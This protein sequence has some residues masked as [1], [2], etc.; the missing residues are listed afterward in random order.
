ME[1]ELRSEMLGVQ[2]DGRMINLELRIYKPKGSGPFPTIVFN[3]GSTGSG[4]D[5]ETFKYPIRV[6]AL[7]NFFVP[8]GWAIIAPA[9]RGRASS[10]GVYDEGFNINRSEGY[11]IEAKRSVKGAKRALQDI[12]ALMEAISAIAFVDSKTLLIGGES[13]GGILSVAYAGMHPE[14]VSGVI[15]FV[16]GWIGAGVSTSEEINQTVF[17]WGANYGKEMLWLYGKNDSYYPISHS[18]KNFEVFQQKGGKGT[19]HDIGLPKGVD[20]HILSM[21]PRQWSSLLE[22]YLKALH[23]PYKEKKG[24]ELIFEWPSFQCGLQPTNSNSPIKAALLKNTISAKAISTK[25]ELTRF[26]GVWEGWMG[27]NAHIDVRAAVSDI[28]DQGATIIL[29]QGSNN[30]GKYQEKLT[31]KFDNN[32]LRGI[33][34]AGTK[35]Y[36][37]VRPDGHMNIGWMNEVSWCTGVLQKRLKLKQQSP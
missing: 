7:A 34:T 1:T 20:G 36:F 28:S 18:Q 15:N 29:A 35:F 25:P 4:Q 3:H 33:D 14:K 21:V 12:E 27:V 16:G 9:R 37:E 26:L 17:N 5:P 8:R 31:L 13:R 23:L 2:L 10:E 11:S 22:E 19:F 32:L 6:T 30:K 24:F